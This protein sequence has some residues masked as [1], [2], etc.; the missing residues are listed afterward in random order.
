MSKVSE[1]EIRRQCF[2]KA[3]ELGSGALPI[4]SRD[5]PTLDMWLDTYQ[6]QRTDLSERTLIMHQVTCG[7][8]LERLGDVRL[9][10][11][12]RAHAADWRAWLSREKRLSEQTVCSHC[13]TAKVI[14]GHAV[15]QDILTYSPFDRL[16]GT[17]PVSAVEFRQL[18]GVEI[19]TL[20]Q[21][22]T[23]VAWQ[24]LFGLCAYAGL[25]RGEAMRLC[26]GDVHQNRIRVR[27][28]GDVTTKARGRD[29]LLEPV[30]AAM[31]QPRGEPNELV[32]RLESQDWHRAA[33]GYIV[34]AGLVPWPKPF[35]TLR[36]NRATSWRQRYPEHV[37]DAWLGHSLDVARRHYAA[38]P[39]AMYQQGSS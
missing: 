2:I 1:R 8:L 28:S 18:S 9:D 33:Q 11:I 10:R 25:R 23:D 24:R 21:S 4:G 31:L 34:A 27:H 36:K 19:Q 39:E 5:T 13:R 22:T 12:T 30:L 32:C 26:W 17:A 16:R 7:Y 35:H 29:V 6:E 20:I 3:A 15:R 37:V 38:V 14:F